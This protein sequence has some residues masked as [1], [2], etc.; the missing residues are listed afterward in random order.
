MAD[1]SVWKA[2]EDWRG[3][4]HELDPLF[5]AAGIA[6]ELDSMVT[7]VLVDLRRA[8]PTAPL[9]TGDKTRDETE[10][11]RFHEAYFRYYDDSLQKVESL[12]QHAWVPE[13]EPIAKEIRAE[14]G[15]MRKAMEESPG[16]V[17]SFEKLEVLLRHYVRLDHP[18]HPVPE[19]ILAER[20]R[21]LVDVAGYPLLVQHAAAQTFSE[22]V[23]PLVT[24]EFRQQLQERIQAYLQTPWLHTR[25]V[26]QWF[27][28]TVLDA[29]LARKKRDATEDARILAS[30][31][32]R[33]PTLSVWIPEF[34]QAD[35]VWY[36][37][38]V[39]ITVSALFME[40][41]WVAVPMM[42]WLH[43][44]LAA[45]RRERKEVEARRAQ[46]VARAVT[47]KKVR[48]RFAT[49]QTTPEKLAFQLRQLDER[50]EYFD[51][52]VYALLRLHQHEA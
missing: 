18:Q 36:L 32:R 44:S 21:A 45:F 49:N 15:R 1:W 2:L 14:L 30:M 7:R 4:K 27:V 6:P 31:S 3:R 8:P 19:G 47:M 34:E 40:W 51:D 33:W 24:P 11:G 41:W 52:N 50:G 5:A 22:M 23:P 9:L 29:A 48:D 26:S 28:T 39:L 46:I 35:Q 38:L 12:L 10:F 43:L 37:I 13:A 16:K 17:P 20:R 25:L 42:I